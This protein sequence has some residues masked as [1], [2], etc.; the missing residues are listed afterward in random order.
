MSAHPQPPMHAQ[1]ETPHRQGQGD[2]GKTLNPYRSGSI[3]Q[4]QGIRVVLLRLVLLL[5]PSAFLLVAIGFRR[6]GVL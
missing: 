6:V 4:A 3:P 2:K 1:K 5:A